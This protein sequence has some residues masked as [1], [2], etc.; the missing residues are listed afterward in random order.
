MCNNYIVYVDELLKLFYSIE[1]L[2]LVGF[3]Q[4]FAKQMLKS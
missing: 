2:A 1:C 4:V 3:L